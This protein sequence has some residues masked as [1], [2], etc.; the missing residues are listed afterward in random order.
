MPVSALG[1][2]DA[3]VTKL[4]ANGGKVE[5][6]AGKLRCQNPAGRRILTRFPRGPWFYHGFGVKKPLP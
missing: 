5:F 1:G 4:S 6:T 2:K 3:A